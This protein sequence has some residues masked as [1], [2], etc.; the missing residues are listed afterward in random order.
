MVQINQ[1]SKRFRAAMRFF[2]YGVMTTAVIA[3]SALVI[4]LSLGYR[5]DKGLNIVREGLLQLGGRP[6]DARYSINGKEY[7]DTTPAKA[8]LPAGDYSI[9][10]HQEGY[11]SW[12]KTS[13]GCR[14]AC[15]LGQLRTPY[16][17]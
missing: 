4:L 13:C 6:V 2:T 9:V 5:F 16:P 10:L 15:S 3:L 7:A 14:R 17:Q 12:Q 8:T 11:R 1:D